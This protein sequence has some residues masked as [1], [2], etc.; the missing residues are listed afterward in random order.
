MQKLSTKLTLIVDACLVVAC[1]VIIITTIFQS[2]ANNDKLMLMQSA[3]G[4][5][6]LQHDVETQADRVEEIYEVFEAEHVSGTAVSTGETAALAS[7]WKKFKETDNDFIAVTDMTGKVIYKSDN[8]KVADFDASAVAGGKTIKGIVK[9]SAAGLTVQYC[10][11]VS[12]DGEVVGASIIGMSM[13][14]LGY[15]DMVKSQT[16]A[17]V[18]IFEGNTRIA[19]TVSDGAGGRAVGTTMAANVEK[20]VIAGGQPYSGQADIL[21][22]NH[23]V[24]YIPMADVNGQIVGAYFAGFSSAESDALATT[25][26]TVSIIIAVVAIVA[27][28][29]II[30]LSLQKLVEKPIKEAN[31]IADS[32][33]NGELNYP[34]STF[35][36][37]NDEIGNFVMKLED[38]KHALQSYV[39]DI[40]SIL[41]AM[42]NG[43]FTQKPSVEYIGDFTEIKTS[44]AK[45][46]ATLG[47]II[48]NMNMSA[49]DVMSGSSQIA[50]GSQTLAAGTT[51]QATAIDELTSTIVNI[52]SQIEQTANN[53][54]KA[55]NLSEQ[56]RDKISVQNGEMKRML[57]AMEDIKTKSNEIQNIIKAIDDIAFQTNILALNAAV[58]A[59]RAGDAGKGFAVVADEVRNLAGKS[60]EAAKNTGDLISATIEAVTNG[61]AI[62]E[63]TA[64]IMKEVIDISGQTDRLI[65]EISTAAASQAESIRQVSIG[66]EQISTVVQQNSA[67]AEETAASCEELSGQSKLLKAQVDKLRV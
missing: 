16:N 32:M 48:S 63:K 26:V 35:K 34:D 39:G 42:A 21:G 45:I 30:I 13:T 49:D 12:L 28:A 5:N 59:A 56:S 41:S 4:V 7:E 36:F 47:Q 8:Y 37:A 14:E 20:Q 22:Q 19:T 51:E 3:T 43:D 27:A 18:T 46:A 6:V 25:M 15:L 40:S 52:S 11:P 10:A 58:E 38:T 66:I 23:Y 54:Q 62:A 31:A 9:D 17:E 64:D 55:N 1:A 60:A 2:L 57:N 67:T 65:G 53:A 29:I 24:D 44:F 61:S 50:D 33:S